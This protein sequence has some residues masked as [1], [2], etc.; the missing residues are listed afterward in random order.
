MSNQMTKNIFDGTLERVHTQVLGL[1]SSDDESL[2]FEVPQKSKVTSASNWPQFLVINSSEKGA[3][4]IQ[5][6][7]VGLAGEPN[8]VQKIMSGFMVE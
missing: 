2:K 1:S 8:S 5:K 3:L 7:V 6:A 4:A